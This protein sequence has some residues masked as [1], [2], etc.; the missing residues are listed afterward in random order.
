MVYWA[1]KPYYKIMCVLACGV[2]IYTL[3][4]ESLEFEVPGRQHLR[5]LS[6]EALTV[7]YTHTPE[8]PKDP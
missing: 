7:R 2:W 5:K 3:T 6:R 4:S 8:G 1:P